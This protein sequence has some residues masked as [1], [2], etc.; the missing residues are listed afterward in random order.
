MGRSRLLD[1]ILDEQREWRS[2]DPETAG[3]LANFGIS[4]KGKQVYYTPNA[5]HRS[6][7]RGNFGL[8][9]WVRGVVDR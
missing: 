7:R 5:H 2:G 9:R 3:R 1:E 4:L 6:L 8:G